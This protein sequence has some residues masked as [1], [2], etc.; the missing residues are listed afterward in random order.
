MEKRHG[1]DQ[2]EYGDTLPDPDAKSRANDDLGTAD[3]ASTRRNAVKG[4]GLA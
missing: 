1:F 4:A 3:V 2:D